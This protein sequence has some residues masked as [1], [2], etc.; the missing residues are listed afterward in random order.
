[1]PLSNKAR[2]LLRRRRA[3]FRAAHAWVFATK[4]H[5]DA[6]GPERRSREAVFM[7]RMASD[8]ERAA[9]RYAEVAR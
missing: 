9:I 2:Q 1:M 6:V 7:A 3:L 4:D 8:L 5:S